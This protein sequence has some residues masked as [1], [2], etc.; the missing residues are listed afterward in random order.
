MFHFKEDNK[1][2]NLINIGTSGNW[3]RPSTG[4]SFQNSFINIKRHYRKVV[5]KKDLK[6]KLTKELNFLIKYFA[7][8]LQ[9][10]ALTQKKC[11]FKSFFFKNKFKDIVS[12]LIG[13]INFFRM[14]L[15][16]LSLPKTKLLY[17][18]IKS[19]KNN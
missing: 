8:I 19:I 17:S 16:I 12:F 2:N 13:D 3:V 6:M 7:I 11:F 14:L 18:M 1:N 9:T 15:I 4:Y 5:K 10:I